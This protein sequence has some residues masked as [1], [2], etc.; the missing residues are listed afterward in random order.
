MHGRE[1][2]SGL[3]TAT[4]ETAGLARAA[5]LERS[6]LAAAR[7]EPL[8][9]DASTR[10]YWRLAGKGLL[11][12]EDRHDRAGFDGFVQLS[13]HLMA[14][15]LSAPRV[16]V[17]DSAH[18]L[19][20]IEDFGPHTYAARLAE[21]RDEAALYALA[22]DA[23]LHLHRHPDALAIDRP[24]FDLETWLQG[25][26]TFARWFAPAIR[27]GLDVDAFAQRWRAL[28]APS[29]APLAA[30]RT[31]LVL[32][33]F[34]IDNLVELD[35]RAGV[36]RCGLL[37][38]QDAALGPAEYDLVS[39]LQDARRDLAPGLE[40]AMLRRYIAGAPADAGDAAA[41]RAR[42][43]LAGAQR[44][45]RIIGVF[46]RL[47]QR[48]GKRRYLRFLPRVLCQLDVALGAAG[49]QHVAG[50]LDDTLPG[51]QA[52]GAALA[53]SDDGAVSR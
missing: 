17:T 22:V 2:A 36:A 42:Y 18:C 25:L 38:F 41:I 23:L 48:D 7:R 4:S 1:Q 30:R 13:A 15:G 44:H 39:L 10:R 21:G 27:P 51:W 24:R 28:W 53:V 49:L 31:A 32:R 35:G 50:F 43:A 8:P 16:Q 26:D 33:D 37:D 9:G 20:L 52:H 40:A 3:S 19:A 14:L 12:M 5:F 45:A 34:H 29:L 46:T 6:G 47:A 11:L